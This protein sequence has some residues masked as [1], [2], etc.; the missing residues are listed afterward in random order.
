MPVFNVGGSFIIAVTC[1][2][3]ILVAADSR[4][5][6]SNNFGKQLAYY[7]N[8][9]KIFSFGKVAIAYTGHD[10]IQN[11]YFGAIIDAFAKTISDEIPVDQVLPTFFSF[12]E[13]NLPYE[14][15]VQV[16]Q[17]V[18]IA[19][20]YKDGKPLGCY[21][22]Y[23]QTEGP[24]SSCGTL[25]ILSSDKT[26]VDDNKAN[27]FSMDFKELSELV[28][29]AIYQYAEERNIIDIGGPV[30]ILAITNDGPRWL[31]SVPM[32]RK[33]DNMHEFASI[34][35]DGGVDLHLLPGVEK[36][37]VEDL[38]RKGEIWSKGSQ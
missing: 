38:I 8:V 13:S 17:Q 28:H 31:S 9:Q 12:I 1:K 23:A 5:T 35:W 32:K 21:Y 15:Q 10:T 14:A 34:Y 19:V 29:E 4:N 30:F 26:I 16:K 27:L 25:T 6:I 18:L 11:L 20:G 7:D 36:Q 33:W 37:E 22:N 24:K 3:G 2:D